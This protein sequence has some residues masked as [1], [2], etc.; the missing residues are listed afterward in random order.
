MIAVYLFVETVY[1]I[2][3][4]AVVAHGIIVLICGKGIEVDITAVFGSARSEVRPVDIPRLAE[5]YRR[6]LVIGSVFK[7]ERYRSALNGN[8]RLGIYEHRRYDDRRQ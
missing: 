3:P 2:K 4:D 6:S 1:P 5:V 7:F 8:D